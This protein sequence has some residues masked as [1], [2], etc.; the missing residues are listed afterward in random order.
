VQNCLNSIR[1]FAESSVRTAVGKLELQEILDNRQVI[2]TKVLTDLKDEIMHWGFNI[3]RC[4]LSSVEPVDQRVKKA[5]NDQIN[6][7]QVSR[8]KHIQADS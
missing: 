4:E 6:A 1:I 3:G 5:L 8:E 2:N 7:E